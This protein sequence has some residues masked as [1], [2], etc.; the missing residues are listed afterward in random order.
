M[1]RDGDFFEVYQYFCVYF[2]FTMLKKCYFASMKLLIDSEIF[3]ETD[4]G[5]WICEGYGNR[6]CDKKKYLCFNI[7]LSISKGMYKRTE[8]HIRKTQKQATFF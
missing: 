4:L 6:T 7:D 8:G 2:N 3:T 1:P 5:I